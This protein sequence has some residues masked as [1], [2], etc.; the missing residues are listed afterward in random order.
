MALTKLIDQMEEMVTET[1]ADVEKFEVRDNNA[2]GTRIRKA[3]QD[4]K[5]IAQKVRTIVSTIKA[6]RKE[7]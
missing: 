4:I 3:M 7:G 2:A 5:I 1:R 6:E